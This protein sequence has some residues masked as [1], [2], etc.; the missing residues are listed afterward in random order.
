MSCSA[1]TH[2]DDLED[3]RRAAGRQR[4]RRH[5]EQQHED[6]REAL[7]LEDLDEAPQRL[8]AV[9]LQPAF[10]LGADAVRHPRS[11]DSHRWFQARGPGAQSLQSLSFAFESFR[12][13]GRRGSCGVTG[14]RCCRSSSRPRFSARSRRRRAPAISARSSDFDRGWKFALV[15]PAD[16]TDPTGAYAHA[17]DP[18]YDDAPW[19]TRRPPARLEHRAR[20]D[21]RGHDERHRLLPGRPG[22]VPQDLH[23]AA[24]ATRTRPSRS[25]STASTWTRSST[26]T[27]SRSPRTR[28]ATPASR[29]TSHDAHTD[30]RTK[31]VVAVQVRNKLPSSRWYSGSGIYRNVHLVVT[32]PTHVERHGTFVTTPERRAARRRRASRTS[33]SRTDVVGAR[34]ARPASSRPCRTPAG[35]PSRA[36]ATRGRGR[37]R[38]QRPAARATR[39]SGRPTTPTS[40][41]STTEVRDGR[42]TVDRTTTPFGVRWFEFDPAN[43]FS[44]NGRT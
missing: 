24:L 18:G 34:P 21:A 10:E 42:R 5:A 17:A 30:G 8:L 33:T 12:S 32:D 3:V 26:S 39:T 20:P 38:D 40:T 4:Q 35:A 16:I 27:A 44:L 22:L 2:G 41:R 19:R 43:G 1:R 37:H 11:D 28:T 23:A 6:D 36:A 15:N 9:A 14:G 29:S 31:N 7:A 13:S 25:S